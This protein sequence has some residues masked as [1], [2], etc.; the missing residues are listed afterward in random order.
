MGLVG[1]FFLILPGYIT[2]VF[3]LLLMFKIFQHLI[4][5][6]LSMRVNTSIFD[7]YNFQ[8]KNNDIVEGEFYDLNEK[9]NLNNSKR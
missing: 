7:T 3:G 4:F 6:I 8:N 9:K 1:S 2:D 5:K